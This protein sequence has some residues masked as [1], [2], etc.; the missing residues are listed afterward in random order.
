MNN[1]VLILKKNIYAPDYHLVYP[2]LLAVILTTVGFYD[3]DPTAS[4]AI[5]QIWLIGGLLSAITAITFV[6]L[7]GIFNSNKYEEAKELLANNLTNRYGIPFTSDEV[8]SII[9]SEYNY[10]YVTYL[11]RAI[12]VTRTNLMSG[13]CSFVLFEHNGQE[14]RIK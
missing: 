11:E 4:D 9:R 5:S 14:V 2:L 7:R 10:V 8:D 1:E 3:W 13:F 12:L 6:L